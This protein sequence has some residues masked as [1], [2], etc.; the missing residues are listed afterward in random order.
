MS[1]STI[2]KTFLS[3]Q[4]A[5]SYLGFVCWCLHP[6][7][8]FREKD[9]LAPNGAGQRQ[10]DEMI[11]MVSTW[12]YTVLPYGT[13]ST[14]KPSENSLSME[15]VINMLDPV[16][17]LK[18]L[19]ANKKTI[20]SFVDVVYKG[21]ST[22]ENL[23]TDKLGEIWKNGATEKA[24]AELDEGIRPCRQLQPA[25]I[26]QIVIG[27]DS[28]DARLVLKHFL[29]KDPVSKSEAATYCA[30]RLMLLPWRPNT[31]GVKKAFQ[32]ALQNVEGWK[33]L[34][35]SVME[36]V[37]P[38]SAANENHLSRVRA[39]WSP[40][41][42][43]IEE[44][45]KH[46]KSLAP[47]SGT[48]EQM[49]WM[50]IHVKAKDSP[51]HGW[52]ISYVQKCCDIKAKA[53]SG[54]EVEHDFPLT[55]FD[56][57]PVFLNEVLPIAGPYISDHGVFVVG[58]PGVGKTPFV[59]VL[60]GGM[61]QYWI[62]TRNLEG[63]KPGWQRGKQ[64]DDFKSS[65]SEIFN[66]YIIDDGHVPKFRMEDIGRAKVCT[67]ISKRALF[68]FVCWWCC[69]LWLFLGYQSLLHRGLPEAH[70]LPLPSS[71]V[72]EECIFCNV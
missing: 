50:L 63:V 56:L 61:G 70:R 34:F 72:G 49:S 52:P 2:T 59:I 29:L 24:M 33:I 10:L 22:Q 12:D 19:S 23:S 9:M 65:M 3:R 51:I 30:G 17:R 38:A 15:D 41:L 7:A 58:R 25:D 47:P 39:E 71:K 21:D 8:Q 43:E 4:R 67:T 37:C 69:I 53:K 40:S 26:M 46:I 48:L 60:A 20:R 6:L 62:D 1:T 16:D 35:A 11:P 31:L 28:E 42:A 13:P 66:G 45:M 18:H 64:F 55:V 68:C 14:Q 27:K 57:H 54:A 36:K 44:G 32:L 5:S